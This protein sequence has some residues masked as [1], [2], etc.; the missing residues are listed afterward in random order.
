MNSKKDLKLDE[1]NSY[2][3]LIVDDNPSIHDDFKK[4]LSAPTNFPF[5]QLLESLKSDISGTQKAPSI[6]LPF[7]L[8]INSAY[9]GE[10]ALKCV[11][12]SIEEND[13]YA[14][15]FMDVVMPPGRDGILITQDVWTIDPDVQVVIC[16]AYSEYSWKDMASIL[17]V[18]DNYLIL[19]KPFD[20]IEVIQMTCCLTQKWD[21]EHQVGHAYDR[22]QMRMK[23]QV[24]EMD[25]W[26]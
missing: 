9:D 2:R 8:I 12:K 14:L 19:K 1:K 21:L 15:I 25:S 26:L 10:E 20:S 4:I 23:K 24:K 22:M 7:D 3:I 16:T 18:N 11:S 6:E 13:P 5:K 17:G